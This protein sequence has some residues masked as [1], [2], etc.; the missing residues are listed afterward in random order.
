VVC[1]LSIVIP[2]GGHSGAIVDRWR[3]PQVGEMMDLGDVVVAVDEVKELLPPRGEFRFIHVTAHVV[4][5][6]LPTPDAPPPA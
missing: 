6:T 5:P 1:K 4:S 3:M 2:G